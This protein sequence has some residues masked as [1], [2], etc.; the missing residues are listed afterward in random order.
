MDTIELV[1]LSQQEMEK[2]NDSTLEFGSLVGSNGDWGERFPE[3]GLADVGG[4]E[5][6][7]TRAEAVSLLEELIEHEYHESS[8]E[9]LGNDEA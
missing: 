1:G 4:D 9:K 6:G 5:E 8:E 7:D 3:D 2:G